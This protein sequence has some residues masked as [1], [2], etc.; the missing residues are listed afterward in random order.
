[1]TSALAQGKCA[2]KRS[3]LYFDDDLILLDIFAEMFRHEYEVKTVAA[4]AEARRILSGTGIDIIISDLS[5]PEI[6]GVDF[7]REA[8]E[9]SPSL[10]RILVTGYATAGDV[11]PEID[12][13]IVQFFLTKPWLEQE[14]Y[15][16]VRRAV[17]VRERLGR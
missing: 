12:N 4:L 11:L 14:M 8:V 6:S 17:T 15:Q 16:V 5:M 10:V 1:M 2:M 3:I 13:G 9:K 7:L